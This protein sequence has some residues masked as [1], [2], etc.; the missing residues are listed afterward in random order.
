M[1][2]GQSPALSNS[3]ILDSPPGSPPYAGFRSPHP[4][5]VST[6]TGGPTLSGWPRQISWSEFREISSR[7]DGGSEDA[8]ISVEL[9]AERN[10]SVERENGQFKLGRVTFK[11]IVKRA[12]SWVVGSQKSDTL[13]AH[14]QG[15]YDI[16]GLFYRDLMTALRNLRANSVADLGTETNRLMGEYDQLADAMSDKYD[17]VQETNHGVNTARQ[18]AWEKQIRD[19]MQNGTKITAPP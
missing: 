7:P 8:Q 2:D 15:H 13:R 3:P 5:G 10:V 1:G 18:Q 4:E 9:Q 16:V 14:E 17:S 19:C 6:S 12:E 11:I